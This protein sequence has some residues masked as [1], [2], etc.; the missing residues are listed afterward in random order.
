[1]VLVDEKESWPR[2]TTRNNVKRLAIT[3]KVL[4]AS[5]PRKRLD[6]RLLGSHAGSIIAA[7]PAV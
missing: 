6:L 4:M 5:T 7:A 1:M 2:E 3:Q